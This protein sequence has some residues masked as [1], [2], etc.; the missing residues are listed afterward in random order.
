MTNILTL[1][2]ILPKDLFLLIVSQLENIFIFNGHNQFL[3][4]Q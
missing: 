2:K 4:C 1:L 3:V